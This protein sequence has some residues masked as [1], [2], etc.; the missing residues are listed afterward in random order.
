MND[1]IPIIYFSEKDISIKNI[2]MDKSFA[3]LTLSDIGINEKNDKINI[4][5]SII[6]NNNLDDF[7]N[8]FSK[9]KRI[10]IKKEELNDIPLPIF[11]CL[12]CSNEKIAFNH[13]IKEILEN[14]YYILTTIYDMKFINKLIL[15]HNIYNIFIE[16]KEYIKKYYKYI[17]SKIL[18][19]NN[20][21]TRKNI[22][23]NEKITNNNYIS[24]KSTSSNSTNTKF[25][26]YDLIKEQIR[27]NNEIK[28]HRKIKKKDIKWETKYYNIWNPT[29]EPIYIKLQKNIPKSIINNK[30]SLPKTPI[31]L[32]KNK[33]NLKI[34]SIIKTKNKDTTNKKY[35]IKIPT[36]RNE[37]Y[38]AN[39][40]FQKLF[41]KTSNIAKSSSKNKS[42]NK[43]NI[44]NININMS[45][46]KKRTNIFVNTII[47]KTP[48][49]KS[50]DTKTIIS[51][52]NNTSYMKNKYSS[53]NNIVIKNKNIKP[54]NKKKYLNINPINIFQSANNI[55][56]GKSFCK[57]NKNDIHIKKNMNKTNFKFLYYKANK[58]ILLSNKF[59]KNI[60]RDNNSDKF[61]ISNDKSS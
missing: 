34:Y 40:T 37:K 13:M 47:K 3:N 28:I 32:N 46:S 12:Y 27:K 56:E 30:K 57:N 1:S 17:E 25:K 33:I 10:K 60:N 23:K 53:K 21:K 4:T 20:N 41:N 29:I 50:L 15:S 38:N 22:L 48:L 43:S 52:I 24:K 61:E 42:L 45:N 9:T 59:L 2:V 54:I 16:N 31:M 36:Y 51:K 19:K 44:K 8:I 14:K 55:Y 39:K 58:N 11:S 26:F 18:I 7:N 49:K 35:K 6:S 5:N